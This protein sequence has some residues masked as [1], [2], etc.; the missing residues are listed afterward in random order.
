MSTDPAPADERADL[1]LAV[2]KEEAAA[3]LI[4]AWR[5]EQS[6]YRCNRV[7]MEQELADHFLGLAREAAEHLL[8]GRQLVAYDP[9]WPL[10][11][12]EFFALPNDPAPGGNL[13]ELMADYTNLPWFNKTDLV[14][15]RLYVVA[16]STPDGTAFFGRRMAYLQVLGRRSKLLKLTWNGEVFHELQDSFA[17]F[18]PDFDWIVWKNADGTM[19]V[20]DAA[21]FH[22]EF[23]D[24]AALRAAVED[25]VTQI[26]ARV[27]IE[28]AD[29]LV[30]RCRSNVAMAS[31]LKHVV[32]QGITDTPVADLRAYGENHGI[33]VTWNGDAMVYEPTLQRQWN[34]LKL[35]D[36]DHTLGPVSQR[37]YE[38]SAKR[39]VS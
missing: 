12:D 5:E 38:S 13:F 33:E 31:K 16:V 17:T 20:L 28:N 18:S 22:G 25:H 15:P 9:E 36:E 27:Q 11:K 6:I 23:R 10:K 19:H 24:L 7:Q 8:T 26:R 4:L 34:I 21:A 30:A 2:S 29:E 3:N 37:T 32:E 39:R 14:K 1:Q 35:L